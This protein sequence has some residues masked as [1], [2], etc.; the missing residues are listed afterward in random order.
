MIK[1]LI[2][3]T[4][5]IASIAV[6]QSPAKAVECTWSS[7]SNSTDCNG[8]H[9]PSGAYSNGTIDRHGTFNGTVDGQWVT[10]PEYGSCY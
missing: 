10:C 9:S 5:A 1:S 4:F 8:Y 7:Y 2:T 6:L 3:A